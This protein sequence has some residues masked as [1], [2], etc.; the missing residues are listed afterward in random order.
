MYVCRVQVNVL[1]AKLKQKDKCGA[2][3]ATLTLFH[4]TTRI[5]NGQGS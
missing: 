4:P 2:N 1:A 5:V 3:R